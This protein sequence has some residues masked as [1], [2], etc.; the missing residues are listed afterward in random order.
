MKL[1]AIDTC[2]KFVQNFGTY[3]PNYFRSSFTKSRLVDVRNLSEIK[4]TTDYYYRIPY[5]ISYVGVFFAE[6]T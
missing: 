6:M 2:F 5:E 4:F 1:T 3:L